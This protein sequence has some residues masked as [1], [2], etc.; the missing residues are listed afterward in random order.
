[1]HKNKL[2][3]WL[4]GS[5]LTIEVG[6]GTAVVSL[7]LARQHPDQQFLALDRKSDR[8]GKAARVANKEGLTNIAFYQTDFKELLDLESLKG[9][10]TVVWVTFPDPYPKKGD[11]KHRL[12]SHWSLDAITHLLAPAGLLK[13][14]TDNKKLFD[15]SVQQILAYK[16]LEIDFKTHD[17]HAEALEDIGANTITRY[18]A[19]FLADGLTTN[20]LIARKL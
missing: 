17:L 19:M 16:G 10:A 12:T 11:A 9:T 13:F 14:K 18:E 1:M 4:N 6:A 20:F 3:D 7:E 2:A 8:L 5:Q 15:W